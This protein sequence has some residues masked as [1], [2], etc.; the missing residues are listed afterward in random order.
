MLEHSTV[1]VVHA[2][3]GNCHVFVDASAD[4]DKAVRITVNAKAQRPGVCNAAETLLVH[5]DVAEAFLPVVGAELR[6]KGVE[7]YADKAA[8]QALGDVPSR[9]ATRTHYEAEFL[10]L[11]MAVRVVDSL[12]E[13]LDHIATF[14]TGH[15]E[16]IV[17]EDVDG[18]A[19]LR[20]RRRRRLRLRQRLDQVHRRRAVRPRRRARDLDA[21]AARAGPDRPRGPH[22]REVRA[23]GRR[24]GQVLRP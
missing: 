8:A 24:A 14:G 13:A 19:P 15:S 21:E 17:A 11:R 5:R 18:G 1:P 16:A 10:D 9:R 20:R 23:L 22:L 7:L 6:R 2:A 12:D 4:L 3:G